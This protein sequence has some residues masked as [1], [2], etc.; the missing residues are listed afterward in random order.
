MENLL[1]FGKWD[2]TGVSVTDISLKKYINIRP[3]VVPNTFGKK[4]N[5]RFG[6]MEMHIVE[7]LADKLTVTGHLKDSRVHKRIS[8]RD[9]GKKQRV[10]R[11]VKEAFELIEK[12][13]KQNPVQMLVKA[14][15]NTAPREE[16]TKIR[17][18]GIIVHRA[19]DVAPSRRLDLSLSFITHGAGQRSFN[20]KQSVA[21]ALSEE[22]ISAVNND[23]KT[24]SIAK[25]SELERVAQ[26]A[27]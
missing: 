2:M 22:I 21:M 17:Q 15:E 13:T 25:S 14:V 9:T 23:N 5:K 8:G 19:V 18:G 11:I 7:R 26:S 27:R 1:L 4:A 24:Y 12:K 6:K 20:K 16:T 3:T 10:F